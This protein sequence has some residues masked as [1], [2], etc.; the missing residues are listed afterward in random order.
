MARFTC[1]CSRRDFLIKGMYGLGVGATLPVLLNRTSAALAAQALQGTSMEDSPERILVVVE[2]SGGNDGLNTV[3][4]Y[5]DDAYYRARP[6]IGIPKSEVIKIDDHFGL[7]PS[8]VGFERLYKDGQMA[9]VHGCGYDNPSLSH[10]SSMG[11]WHTGVPNGGESLG[12]LGRLADGAYDHDAQGNRIVNIGTR[13]SLAV[14]AQHHSPLVFNDPR[15]FRREGADSEKT[16]IGRLASTGAVENPALEFLAGTAKNAA[17]SSEFVRQASAAYRTTV[18]Y[19]IGG[20]SGPLRQVAALINAE[21]PTRLYYVVY[22]GNSFDTHVHQMDPHARL[23]AYTADAIRGF[24]TDLD[25]IGRGDDVAMM[26]FTEFGRRVEEN[27][28]LGTDHGTATPMFVIGNHVKGGLYG[29][30]PSL[31]E[32]DDGNLFKTTDFRRVYATM[33]EEWLRFDQSPQ[34]LKGSFDPMG[35]FA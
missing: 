20:L 1:G 4:P 31:T 9:V 6:T 5:G 2:L 16:A 25:R 11:F 7:H 19:G 35:V 32:L 15:T 28:S 14:R 33:I 3:V 17:E 26:V 23:L 10:F 13:Q 21:M 18:D 27:G 24:M 30:P 8:M 29:Q 12:W 34:V 22:Q